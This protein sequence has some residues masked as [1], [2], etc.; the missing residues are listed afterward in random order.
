MH[1]RTWRWEAAHLREGTALRS[2]VRR[3]QHAC[4]LD[5]LTLGDM[6]V[7]DQV[8]PNRVRHL[9][10]MVL[11]QVLKHA[12]VGCLDVIGPGMVV[13]VHGLFVGVQEAHLG[14]TVLQT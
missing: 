14:T 8:Q 2:R 10:G 4:R 12:L 9:A 7:D 3:E 11:L 1:G 13:H 6:A 5:G